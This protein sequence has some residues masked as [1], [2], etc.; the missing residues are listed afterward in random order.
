MAKTIIARHGG[1][2]W[3]SSNLNGGST[4]TFYLPTVRL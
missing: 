1:D 3:A 2:L 4:F